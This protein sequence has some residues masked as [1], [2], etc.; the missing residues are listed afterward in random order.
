MYF[1]QLFK[2]QKDLDEPIYRQKEIE[3]KN[4]TEKEKSITLTAKLEKVKVEMTT[5]K[6]R[7]EG[8]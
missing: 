8:H 3:E 7:K 5:Y 6:S 4:T 1:E 2:L